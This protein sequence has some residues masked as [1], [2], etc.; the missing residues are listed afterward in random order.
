MAITEKMR[1]IN[2]IGSAEESS[3]YETIPVED[4]ILVLTHLL[5]SNLMQ[6]LGWDWG[7]T[8]SIIERLVGRPVW[9][10]EIAFPKMIYREMRNGNKGEAFTNSLKEISK[11]KPIISVVIKEQ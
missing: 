2:I 7:K 3:F 6:E 10:H 9:T 1:V 5:E 4:R 11:T 8:H